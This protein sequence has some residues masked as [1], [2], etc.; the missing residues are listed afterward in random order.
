MAYAILD[1]TNTKAYTVE[2]K[3][4]QKLFKTYEEADAY[5][6]SHPHSVMSYTAEFKGEC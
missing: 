1:K 2:Y 3:G 5:M 6:K 4:E